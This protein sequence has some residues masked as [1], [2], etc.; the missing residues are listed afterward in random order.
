MD[1]V[2]RMANNKV[3][4][5]NGEVLLDLTQDTVTPE[6]MLEGITAHNAAGK[7]IE[8][9]LQVVPSMIVEVHVSYDSDRNATYSAN[10]TF[11]EIVTA[12]QSG[13]FV[14]ALLVE[15]DQRGTYFQCLGTGNRINSAV[16]FVCTNSGY[17]AFLVVSRQNSWSSSQNIF[18]PT[19]EEKLGAIVKYSDLNPIGLVPAVAGTDYMTPVPVTTAD[20][21]KFLRV[22]DGAWAAA[23]VPDANG[24]SF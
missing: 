12:I 8:G 7:I 23:T 15:E 24:V 21:G 10:T 5:A 2:V 17:Q 14:R 19:Q 4:L 20:N 16:A 22:V 3:E 18:T 13:A 1:K 6:A 11:D 9:L